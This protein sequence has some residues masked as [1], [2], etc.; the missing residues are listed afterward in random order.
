MCNIL[1]GRDLHSQY[2]PKFPVVPRVATWK[3]ERSESRKYKNSK[4][5]RTKRLGL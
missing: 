3:D 4:G 5:G 2:C 1:V